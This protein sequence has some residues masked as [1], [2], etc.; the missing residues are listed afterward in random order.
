MVRLV[1][2]VLAAL[3]LVLGPVAPSHAENIVVPA[4][5]TPW[6]GKV[7]VGHD[8]WA[9]SD[10]AFQRTPNDSAALARNVAAWFMG[11]R[12]GRF[13]V[14]SSSFGLRDK[15]LATTMRNA[16]HTWTVRT[17]VAFTLATLQQYDAVFL[18]GNQVDTAVLIDYVRAGGHVFLLGGTGIGGVAEAAHWNGFLNA[19]G[20]NMDLKYDP[21]R[22]PA[23]YPVASPS[24]LFNG[25]RNLYEQLG[26]G[27]TKID[28]ADDTAHILVW[29]DQARGRGIYAIYEAR[30][31][32]VAAEI[33]PTV[34]NV[35]SP[36]TLTLSIAGSAGVDV[37]TID[38]A[39][40]D[41]FGAR[42][43]QVRYDHSTA[44]R[45]GLP[46]LG[47]LTLFECGDAD[48]DQ[49]VDLVLTFDGRVVVQGVER[50]L[51]RALRDDETV[52]LTLIGRLKP[53]YGGTPILGEA[54]I[55]I[56]KPNLLGLF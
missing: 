54:L 44:T 33:C 27:I 37:R 26:N 56:E 47:L 53:E 42:A 13:L 46:L 19:F 30:V 28:P 32:A 21:A 5:D 2:V 4:V 35:K 49:Y 6:P 7:F 3:A 14:Y 23:I 11:G 31:V 17:D 24:P 50:A 43:Q 34:V 10:W 29:S 36:G 1:G 15:T 25:V 38:P 16:G 9:L 40:V 45:P 52:A 41:L 55:E 48:P 8:E 39:S 18:A 22:P 51:G 12:P 20:L